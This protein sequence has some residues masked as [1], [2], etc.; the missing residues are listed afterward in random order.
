MSI[1][2]GG[3]LADFQSEAHRTHPQ[4]ELLSNMSMFNENEDVDIMTWWK[5]NARSY[6]T[7][8]M[9]VRDV[10]IVSVSTSLLKVVL[11]R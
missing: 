4:N 3:L 10:F 9:M 2:S 11:V 7:L 5:R 1:S 6:P 8:V